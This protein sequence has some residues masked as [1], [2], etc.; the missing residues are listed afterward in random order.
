MNFRLHQANRALAFPFCLHPP[1][2]SRQAILETLL[3]ERRIAL[4]VLFQV[5]SELRT[6]LAH[7]AAVAADLL[8][9]DVI[10]E[11]VG[12]FKGLVAAVTCECRFVVCG[13]GISCNMGCE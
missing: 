9:E 1:E 4:H 13:S 6:G 11:G 10:Q 5:E 3:H 7:A 2:F 8:L 12:I